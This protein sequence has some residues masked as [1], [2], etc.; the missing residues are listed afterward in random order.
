MVSS[1]LLRC[2]L[3]LQ[4]YFLLSAAAAAAVAAAVAA[5]AAADTVEDVAVAAVAAEFA[6]SSRVSCIA[7]STRWWPSSHDHCASR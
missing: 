3:P 2:H 6:W 1:R 4:Q 7:Q 5:G